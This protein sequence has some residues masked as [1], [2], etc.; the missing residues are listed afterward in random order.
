MDFRIAEFLSQPLLL[1]ESHARWLTSMF[2][3]RGS[4]SSDLGVNDV[5]LIAEK[6]ASNAK[7]Q[8]S[9][10]T[11]VLPISGMIDQRDSMMMQIFGGTSVESLIQGVDICLNEPLIGG[12]IFNI[13]SP[14]GSAYGV[15][16]AADYIYTARSEIAMVSI[17]NSIMASAAYYLGSAASRVYASPSSVTGS[18]GVYLEHYDQS[19]A[20]QE[21]GVTATIVRIPEYKAEGHPDEP[22]STEGLAQMKH[23]CAAIYEQFSGDVAKYRGVSRGTVDEEYGMGRTL[24]ASQAYSCGMVDKVATLSEVSAGMRTG[25]IMRSLAQSSKM[26]LAVDSVMARNRMNAITSGW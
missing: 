12:I 24:N 9:R 22:L 7:A 14:G 25:S 18:I 19:K 3:A 11:A 5:R 13:Y 2:K 8:S 6:Q 16:D 20:L 4:I 1:D 26:G 15:K 21:Q 10:V 17:S 23:R